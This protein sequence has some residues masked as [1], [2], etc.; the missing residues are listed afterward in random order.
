M[1]TMRGCTRSSLGR[2]NRA[3][4][5]LGN[6]QVCIMWLNVTFSPILL[7]CKIHMEG[8]VDLNLLTTERA[9]WQVCATSDHSALL[10]LATET[11]CWILAMLSGPRNAWF[12]VTLGPQVGV[13]IYKVVNRRKRSRSKTTSLWNVRRFFL[14]QNMRSL[15]SVAC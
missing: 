1:L 7:C 4:H 5:M 10:V 2:P 9:E 12:G 13:V 11:V 8:F 15:Y 3:C 14:P 6:A